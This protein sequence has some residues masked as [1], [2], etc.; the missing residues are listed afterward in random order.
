MRVRTKLIESEATG[1]WRRIKLSRTAVTIMHTSWIHSSEYVSEAVPIWLEGKF[2]KIEPVGNN[3][4]RLSVKFS[5]S[6]S[7]CFRLI[8]NHPSEFSYFCSFLSLFIN[9]R[10]QR[11]IL[12]LVKIEPPKDVYFKLFSNNGWNS[13][14]R[15]VLIYRTHNSAFTIEASIWRECLWQFSKFVV[16]RN[17][18]SWT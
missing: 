11:K 18:D 13:L 9:T 17:S 16:S 14:P 5:A 1:R 12:N 3:K 4:P 8:R 7:L 6:S 2:T 15:E 10:R